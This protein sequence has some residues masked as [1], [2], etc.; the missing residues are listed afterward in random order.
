MNLTKTFAVW[1]EEN[2]LI[3]QPKRDRFFNN[4]ISEPKLCQTIIN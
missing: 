4:Y 2:T 3:I 1:K